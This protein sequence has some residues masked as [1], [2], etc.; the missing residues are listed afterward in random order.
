MIVT[1]FF[2]ALGVL[3]TVWY[4]KSNYS[5]LLAGLAIGSWIGGGVLV[6]VYACTVPS[7]IKSYG[8][9]ETVPSVTALYDAAIQDI[10]TATMPASGDMALENISHSTQVAKALADKRDY[11]AGIEKCKGG[12]RR[13]YQNWFCRQF[14]AKPSDGLLD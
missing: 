1:L 6:I 4:C 5:D 2:L 12:L 11:L 9:L 3:F 13:Y 7:T 8:E 14:M 10:T